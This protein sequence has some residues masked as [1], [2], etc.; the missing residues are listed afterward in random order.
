MWTITL[1]ELIKEKLLGHTRYR[2]LQFTASSAS[3]W[4]LARHLGALPRSLLRSNCFSRFLV[5]GR[6]ACGT[7]GG[8]SSVRGA[9]LS[10]STSGAIRTQPLTGQKDWMLREIFLHLC[11]IPGFLIPLC[12]SAPTPNSGGVFVIRGPPCLRWMPPTPPSP[13]PSRLRK[14]AAAQIPMT[15]TV[16]HFTFS[17]L[18]LYKALCLSIWIT[19]NTSSKPNFPFQT[20]QNP[21]LQS[22]FLVFAVVALALD[23][24]SS[25]SFSHECPSLE[26]CSL[27]KP[28]NLFP[29]LLPSTTSLG[30]QSSDYNSDGLLVGLLDSVCIFQSPLHNQQILL[31]WRL[32]FF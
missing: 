15:H 20:L 19:S 10:M 29:S 3:A 28:A 22:G 31:P 6:A 26:S 5:K 25:I 1:T 30:P 13:K 18:K 7:A 17:Y 12:P 27:E 21:K 16:L 2:W 32:I 4:D 14:P 11:W 8:P 9:L 24:P 23:T